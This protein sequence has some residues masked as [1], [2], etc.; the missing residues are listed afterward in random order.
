M[1]LRVNYTGDVAR[2]YASAADN[3]TLDDL[4]CDNFFNAPTDGDT[5]WR[6][7]LSRALPSG[8]P[9]PRELTLRV[10][11]LRADA[12]ADVALDSWPVADF[13]TGPGGSALVLHGVAATQV[14]TVAFA[15]TP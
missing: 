11:P 2:L 4:L 10:L 15:A 6:V 8:A 5:A 12:D 14:A 3:A 7:G 9:L 1:E 13:G